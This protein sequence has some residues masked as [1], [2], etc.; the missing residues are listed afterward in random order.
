M[1]TSKKVQTIVAS[2]ASKS[3]KMRQLLAAGMTRG[4]VAKVLGVRYQFVRNVELRA[5]AKA[6][7]LASA[8]VAVAVLATVNKTDQTE[9]EGA[10]EGEGIES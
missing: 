4:Q 5:E 6:V 1:I 10:P 8:A 7:K 9:G 2:S 3:D